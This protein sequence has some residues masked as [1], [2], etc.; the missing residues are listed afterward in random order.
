MRST[1]K[2]HARGSVG[3][4]GLWPDQVIARDMTR[5]TLRLNDDALVINHDELGIVKRQQ[6]LEQVA[7]S[8]LATRTRWQRTTNEVDTLIQIHSE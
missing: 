4:Y 5:D 8:L 2:H 1:Y 3:I 6:P 7:I